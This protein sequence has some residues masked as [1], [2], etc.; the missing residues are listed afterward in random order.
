MKK[1]IEHGAWRKASYHPKE[2]DGAKIR[3]VG[4]FTIE[5]F[6]AFHQGGILKVLFEM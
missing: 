6:E 2:K 1:C 4:T 3:R 5:G